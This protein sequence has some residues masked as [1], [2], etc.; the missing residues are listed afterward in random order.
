[1]RGRR[2]ERREVPPDPVYHDENVTRFIN[3]I[4]WRGKKSLAESIFYGAMEIIKQKTGEEGIEVF[5]RAIENVR[6]HVEVRSRRIGGS[7]YQVPVDIKPYKQI[8]H[9]MRWI[10]QFA[11]ARKGKPMVEKL[12]LELIDAAAGTGASVK[13][14]DDTHRMAEANRAFA[15]FK[16]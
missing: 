4:M 1:M 13:K 10:I 12:A 6:P 8:E 3:K 2:A 15:H 7:T 11:R 5:R 16:I 14:K 9:A